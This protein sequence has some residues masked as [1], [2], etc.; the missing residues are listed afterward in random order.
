MTKAT[1]KYT[2]GNYGLPHPLI[3][4]PIR[5][6]SSSCE[7]A[8]HLLLLRLRCNFPIQRRARDSRVAKSHDAGESRRTQSA[9][10]AARIR[11][12]DMMVRRAPPGAGICVSG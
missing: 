4:I 6:L 5:L 9:V 11:M 12:I 10:V 3:Q 2:A 7:I 8:N 1:L